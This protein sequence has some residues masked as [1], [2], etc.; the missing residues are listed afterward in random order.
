MTKVLSTDE[1]KRAIEGSG[2]DFGTSNRYS[3]NAHFGQL[4]F[5][6]KVSRYCMMSLDEF[7][8][9]NKEKLTCDSSNDVI[10]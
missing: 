1:V 3:K 9:K 7:F 8:G 6:V 5:A 2:K 4:F 10:W